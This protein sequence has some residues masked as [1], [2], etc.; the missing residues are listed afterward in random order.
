MAIYKRGRGFEL[1]K[2]KNKSSKWPEGDLI[3]GL[4]DCESNALTTWPHCLLQSMFWFLCFRVFCHWPLLRTQPNQP[5]TRN[6]CTMPDLRLRYCQAFLLFLFGVWI[7]KCACHVLL[8]LLAC[9]CWVTELSLLQVLCWLKVATMEVKR[10]WDTMQ[11]QIQ[12][13]R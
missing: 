11:C 12:T 5:R 10:T 9:F 13:L 7:K 8:E 2:T 4:L 3:P 6:I 1:G